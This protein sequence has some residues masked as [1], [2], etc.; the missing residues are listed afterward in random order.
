MAK[1]RTVIVDDHEL[2][3]AGLRQLL[4]A[5]G[6]CTVVGTAGS[7]SEG[8]VTAEAEAPDVVLVDLRL[9]DRGGLDFIR[10]LHLRVPSV[11]IV[12]VTMSDDPIVVAAAMDSGIHAYVVKSSS[13]RELLEAVGAAFSGSLYLDEAAR[14]SYEQWSLSPVTLNDQELDILR[15]LANGLDHARVAASL[16]MSR[17]TVNRHIRSITTKLGVTNSMSAVSEATRR[18]VI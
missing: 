13:P 4:E 8:L 10:E 5:S 2:V 1:I 3:V 9:P 6:R 12:V 18:G 11:K 7:A 17:S 15:L 16:N 14:R